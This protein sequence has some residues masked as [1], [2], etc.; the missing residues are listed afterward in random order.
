[1][2]DQLK[3]KQATAAH[4]CDVT[5][6]FAQARAAIAALGID[7]W[8]DGYPSMTVLQEDVARKAA[9]V[10]C[11]NQHVQGYFALMTTPDP[12]YKIIKDGA[13]LTEGE[14]Y[15]TLHRVAMSDRLRGHGGAALA[16]S[17]AVAIALRKGYR[18][19]RVDTH[20]GNLRMRKFLEKQGFTACGTIYLESG[21]ERVAYERVL[22]AEYASAPTVLYEDRNIMICQKPVGQPSQPDPAHA[23]GSDL[24][25]SLQRWRALCGYAPEVWA[26]H[27]L[28]TATGGAIVYAKDAQSAAR[29]G[30]MMIGKQIKKQ[31]LAVV[32]GSLTPERGE[33]T[34]YLY[35]DKQKN[36]AF[37]VDKPRN[38]VKQ[39]I[40]DYQTLGRCDKVS[41]VEV[42]L[43]TGRTHQIRA[44]LSHM[45]HPLLGDGKYGSREKGCTTALWAYK[46]GV[47]HP[48]TGKMI[49]ICNP[50]PA[51]YP[52]NLFNIKE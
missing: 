35:H 28:D 14:A 40:L 31:Y 10:L 5:E 12:T 50:P 7:Q 9:F 44:Q 49:E 25:S 39:A 2:Q 38:G 34:D 19:V 18:S 30:G 15:V 41:L 24:L 4:L 45:G 23:D 37:V 8:Q 51:A 22:D 47:T 48:V 26:V 27:R 3:I 16:V 13:W 21:A 6:I 20:K 36:K 33:L 11:Q 43:Q 32:H 46:L 52:W 29:L 1:M 42:T 17:Y